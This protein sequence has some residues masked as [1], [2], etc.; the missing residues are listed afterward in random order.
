M[1]TILPKPNSRCQVN[2]SYIRKIKTNNKWHLAKKCDA[3]IIFV[4]G[5]NCNIKNHLGCCCWASTDIEPGNN[6][7]WRWQRLVGTIFFKLVHHLR[8]Y[9]S[10]HGRQ[11]QINQGVHCNII[12]HI[13]ANIMHL[14]SISTTLYIWV[15]PLSC[16]CLVTYFCNHLI[17]FCY[18]LIVY[19]WK[20]KA[21][22]LLYEI[23][24]RVPIKQ[25]ILRTDIWY[26]Y[27]VKHIIH[28][29]SEIYLYIITHVSYF[30]IYIIQNPPC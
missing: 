10:F 6:S 17:I 29:D 7:I 23:R 11:F 9:N 12:I 13:H 5:W 21:I 8:S 1:Y 20:S 22:Y 2:N 3:F 14:Q 4:T 27:C 18:H 25:I 16:S 19:R 26:C 28:H 30:V 15:I 24:T